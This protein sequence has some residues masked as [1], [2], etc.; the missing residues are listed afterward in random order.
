[1]DIPSFYVIINENDGKCNYKK[2][3]KI[4]FHQ[5]V[6]DLRGNGGGV[7]TEAISLSGLF[8]PSGPVVQVRDNNGRVRQ[9]FEP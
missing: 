2:W 9:D 1:M 8:I 7:L 3:L 5:L 6:I 4:M